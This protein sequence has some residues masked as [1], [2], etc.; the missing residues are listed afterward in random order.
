METGNSENVIHIRREH[1][2]SDTIK[3]IKEKNGD[4]IKEKF[5]IIFENEL[6]SGPG[7]FFIFQ[8]IRKFIIYNIQ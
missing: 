1:I 8:N 4:K 3:A 6:G 2:V 7:I 5:N